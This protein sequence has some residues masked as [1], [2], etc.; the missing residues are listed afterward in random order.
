ML[1]LWI[2]WPQKNIYGKQSIIKYSGLSFFLDIYRIPTLLRNKK[3]KLFHFVW[4]KQMIFPVAE[5]WAKYTEKHSWA[6]L[7]TAIDP[8]GWFF[9]WVRTLLRCQSS[10]AARP[11]LH[12]G[13]AALGKGSIV[14]TVGFGAWTDL[15]SGFLPSCITWDVMMNV[16]CEVLFICS[17]YLHSEGSRRGSFSGRVL[18]L[19]CNLLQGKC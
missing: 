5:W 19:F 8:S 16:H 14:A 13:R 1:I 7:L 10:Q 4:K 3:K 18:S 9:I 12:H 2:V 11:A 17:I 6:T 15:C